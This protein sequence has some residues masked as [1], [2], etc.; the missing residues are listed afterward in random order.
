[1][2]RTAL[3]W[4]VGLAGSAAAHAAAGWALWLW[5]QPDEIVV[6]P[7]PETELN[8]EAYTLDRSEVKPTT[9]DVTA[10]TPGATGGASLGSGSI[11]VTRAE[12]V[13]APR[14]TSR[15]T[16]PAPQKVTPAATSSAPLASATSAS[17]PVAAVAAQVAPLSNSTRAQATALAPSAASATTTASIAATGNALIASVAQADRPRP[18]A[19]PSAQIAA[20]A[21]KTLLSA[22]QQPDPT[23]L[24]RVSTS[25]RPVPQA[26]PAVS[27]SVAV[28]P[29][30][31]PLATS[32]APPDRIATAQPSSTRVAAAQ[33]SAPVSVAVP[34][35]NQTVSP[36]SGT[37]D[38]LPAVLR[39]GPAAQPARPEVTAVAAAPRVHSALQGASPAVTSV[40]AAT[41][42][43]QSAAVSVTLP[44]ANLTAAAAPTLSA[45]PAV[46]QV[47]SV[48]Q[49]ALSARPVEAASQPDT[50]AIPSAPAPSAPLATAALAA[51]P[52]LAADPPDVELPQ[53]APAPVTVT[54]DAP[55]AAS[56][57][58]ATPELA[59]LTERQ[60]DPIP[61]TAAPV[62]GQ[63]MKAALAFP[64]Q[65]S[66]DID[67]VSLAAFQSFMQPGDLQPGSD[68][69][70]DGV[71][72]LL[73]QVPCSRL[74][75]GFDPETITL[76]LNGHI[77][78]P[79]L[80]PAVVAQLQ[81]Q[82]GADIAIADQMKILKRPQC[83]ALSGI[84]NVGLPNS[85][86][87]D[88]DARLIGDYI[89]ADDFRFTQ[90]QRLHFNLEAPDYDAYV[91]V[92]YFDA[93]GNVLHLAPNDSVP[94]TL[95]PA[96]SRFRVG[97][98]QAGEDGLTLLIGPPYGEEISVSFAASHPLYD[99]LR[100]IVEPAGP[101]LE[102]LRERVGEAR[103]T[104]PDFKG[105]WVYFFVTT[106]AQ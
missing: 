18:V 44:Q 71:A 94:V 14:D 34:P 27:A 82:M 86:N 81:A 61:A 68:Q 42:Q 96:K 105:E 1:M 66:G 36:Q 103:A 4:T 5:V 99:G 95:I 67:P 77:P 73:A 26:S 59:A 31:S 60:P 46:P 53:I 40:A 65:E 90:G 76:T 78:D 45:R 58:S 37:S 13:P 43:P 20:A 70:R 63:R 101:Y 16:A 6:Q 89:Q 85:T 55:D 50:A 93:D 56:V 23:S 106:A 52:A 75:V 11:P 104:H 3:R 33:T 88:T 91:Y 97:T 69:L 10:A 21:P 29:K 100:P 74:Q 80:R 25:T 47:Q 38:V 62:T 49:A 9:P 17:D 64:G 12:P 83:G 54:A 84:A 51:R 102:W 15:A 19:A 22:S 79:E 24:P 92:D 57:P 2:S 41:P 39:V 35:P 32:V 98:S 7:M 87:L 8:L 72:G 48:A 30:S 28:V